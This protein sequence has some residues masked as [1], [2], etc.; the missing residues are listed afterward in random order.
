MV[1]GPGG[2]DLSQAIVARAAARVESGPVCR[3]LGD[4]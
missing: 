4:F 1:A 2:I 3:H